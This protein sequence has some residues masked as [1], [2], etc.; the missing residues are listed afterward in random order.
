MPSGTS[1][2]RYDYNLASSYDGVKFSRPWMGPKFWCPNVYRNYDHNN[3][4]IF[5]YADAVLLLSE[6]WCEKHDYTKSIH[7]LNMV[8]QRAQIDDYVFQT[9]VKLR[10]EIRD[11]RGRE[12]F[13]EWG[14]KYDLV[15]W[16]IWYDQIMAYLTYDTALSYVRPCH[17]YYPIPDVQC[18]RSG[19]ALTN[20]EY[21]KYNLSE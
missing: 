19:R 3:Y 4:K 18:Q 2:I 13:G 20:P 14:R 6:A 8:R 15:R 21:D 10:G 16:G 9:E 7:Y 17:E 12:L 11:E 1:D 5:R